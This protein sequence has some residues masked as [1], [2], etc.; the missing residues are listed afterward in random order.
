MSGESFCCVEEGERQVKIVS[1]VSDL[2]T[3]WVAPFSATVELGGRGVMAAHRFG[4]HQHT[5]GGE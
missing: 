1:P 5:A 3:G 4:W 2:T